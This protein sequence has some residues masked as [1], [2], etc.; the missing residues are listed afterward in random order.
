MDVQNCETYLNIF[1]TKNNTLFPDNRK[2]N[3][4]LENWE[5]ANTQWI[6]DGK[7]EKKLDYKIEY[8]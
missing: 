4:D 7:R 2:I 5:N 6:Y 1:T 3:C 8:F